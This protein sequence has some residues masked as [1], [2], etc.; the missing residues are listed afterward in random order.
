MI[1][2]VFVALVA[3]LA[4]VSAAVAGTPNYAGM[5]V[6]A[7]DPPKPTPAFAFADLAGK[8][9]KPDDVRGKVTMLVFWATW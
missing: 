3:A 9:I 8:T 2:L 7:Y 4:L 5:Q 1:R 6:Q